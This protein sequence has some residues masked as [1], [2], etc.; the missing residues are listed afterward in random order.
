MQRQT[1]LENRFE[2]I[3]KQAGRVIMANDYPAKDNRVL[4]EFTSLI[5]DGTAIL[6][7]QEYDTSLVSLAVWDGQESGQLG[8]TPD[9]L[10]RWRNLDRKI[11]IIN[12]LQKKIVS[13][14]KFLS[15]KKA[16]NSTNNPT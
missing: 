14:F 2:S 4:L 6:R 1:R 9:V 8:E 16:N 13:L 10:S 7:A 3:L 15:D 11:E 5:E 12:T